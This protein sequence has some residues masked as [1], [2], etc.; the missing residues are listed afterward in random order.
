MHVCMHSL[1]NACESKTTQEACC[2]P[3]FF[4]IYNALSICVLQRTHICLRTWSYLGAQ[5]WVIFDACAMRFSYGYVLQS[6]RNVALAS[7]ML[8]YKKKIH[9]QTRRVLCLHPTREETSTRKDFTCALRPPQ[10]NV[11]IRQLSACGYIQIRQPTMPYIHA[12]LRYYQKY[13]KSR[14]VPHADT[15]FF[16][17]VCL[18]LILM[19]HHVFI[20]NRL[21]SWQKNNFCK[22]PQK[23][24][25]TSSGEFC[26]PADE[27]ISH[28]LPL[29]DPG[30]PTMKTGSS[31]DTIS[32]VSAWTTVDF[33]QK[34]PMP[35]KT[36]FLCQTM[37]NTHALVSPASLDTRTD[38][39]DCSWM[40]PPLR[41]L[42]R[43]AITASP[44][45]AG[46][47]TCTPLRRR[48][49]LSQLGHVARL[50]RT[51]RRQG[52][53]FEG[54]SEVDERWREMAGKRQRSHC[55]CEDSRHGGSRVGEDRETLP[56]Q[57]QADRLVNCEVSVDLLPR[58]WGQK[59]I[60]F[61]VCLASGVL[62]LFLMEAFARTP[63]VWLPLVT[64]SLR[65]IFP[66]PRFL[67]FARL[68]DKKIRNSRELFISLSSSWRR[69]HYAGLTDSI[70]LI[71]PSWMI[72]AATPWNPS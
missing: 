65:I 60:L 11:G 39:L 44:T 24:L 52:W 31:P 68:S 38:S 70:A 15:E 66:F 17:R 12:S 3:V 8:L 32:I 64:V 30:A 7:S 21:G 47:N 29:M 14:S 42:E 62:L 37:S 63:T 23:I 51:H 45:T 35:R 10:H 41:S 22:H 55:I 34:E 16:S 50:R 71:S 9:R 6:C 2:W 36:S 43:F 49:A 25:P 5:R 19:P 57:V 48:E 67:S 1:K 56:A 18:Q 33:A 72:T 13:W 58:K 26:F 40:C 54:Q 69:H 27:R 20:E 53:W 59:T 46:G 28:I 61:T 4:S